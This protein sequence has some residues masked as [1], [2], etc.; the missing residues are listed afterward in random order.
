MP[1]FFGQQED[2][3]WRLAVNFEGAVLLARAREQHELAFILHR[4]RLA[5]DFGTADVATRLGV[6]SQDLRR[7]LN[8]YLPAQEAD[9]IRWS[10]YLGEPRRTYQ[11]VHLLANPDLAQLLPALL[12]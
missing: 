5:R 6:N 4:R 12:P 3:I 9:L 7:K 10:W 2:V 8:G 11:A 1:G